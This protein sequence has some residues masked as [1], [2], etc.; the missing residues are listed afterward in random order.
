M[1]ESLLVRITTS[2]IFTWILVHIASR[3]DPVLF[4]ATNGRLTLFGPTAF[5]MVTITMI[6]RKSG[7][8]RTAHLATIED[9]GDQ[10]IVASSMGREKH[11]GWRYNLEANPDIEVQREGESYKATAEVLS[12]EEKDAVWAKIRESVPQIGVYETRTDRNIRVFRL[13]R[14]T[15]ICLGSTSQVY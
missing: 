2:R 12:D 15:R 13:R 5:P 10:L 3:V 14:K 7:K 11:P 4:K 1:N 6:G 8:T 9:E